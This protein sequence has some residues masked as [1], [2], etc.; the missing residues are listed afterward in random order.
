MRICVIYDCLFPYTVGGAER[1]YRKVAERLASDGHEVTFVT[2]RQWPKDEVGEADGVRVVSV[3]PRLDLYTESGRR[4]IAPTLAFGF[5]VLAH[6][7]WHGRRYDV[8]QM[9]S[10]PY[11]SV[12]A[13]GIARRVHGFQLFIDWFEIWTREYWREYLGGIGGM[14]GETIQKLCMRVRHRAFVFSRLHRDRLVEAG[15]RNEIELFEGAY[16]G[17]TEAQEPSP[18]QPT[19]VFAGRHIPEKRVPLLVEAMRELK[20]ELPQARCEIY[21]DGPERERVLKEIM[22]AGL[23]SSVTAPGFVETERVDQ[24]LREA[25]CMVLPS[26]REGYGMVVI[27]SASRGT[28]SVVIAGPDNASTELIEA[29]T[30]GFVAASPDPRELAATI[31]KVFDSGEPLRAS[32]TEWFRNNVERLSVDSSLRRLSEIYKRGNS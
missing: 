15:M 9:A 13:A 2:M 25:T 21:G 19:V 24:A 18:P 28:P 1:W 3:T 23:E 5:G 26:A 27:E 22:E 14:V 10:F 12:L 20:A 17:P 29:G 8:V 16:T 30:N 32:T 7:L 11:F 31:K 6:L 4:K